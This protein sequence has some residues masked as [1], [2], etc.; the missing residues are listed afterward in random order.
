MDKVALWLGY[1]VLLA[2]G[3][4]L[5]AVCL[6]LAA[7]GVWRAWRA[8][9]GFFNIVAAFD[10]LREKQQAAHGV[11]ASDGKTQAGDA[12]S[13]A[14]T[15][16][17]R[18]LP[19]ERPVCHY[20]GKR[21]AYE[22]AACTCLLPGFQGTPPTWASEGLRA[23]LDKLPELTKEDKDALLAMACAGLDHAGQLRA[24]KAARGYAVKDRVAISADLARRLLERLEFPGPSWLENR[25]ELA[26]ELRAILAS[27]PKAAVP[28]VERDA[29][30]YRWLREAHWS[31]S[32]LCVVADPKNSVKLGVDC[33]SLGRL[34]EALDAAMHPTT[35]KERAME[36]V[37]DEFT[38]SKYGGTADVV[39]AMSKEIQRLR[40]LLAQ[41]QVGE[42]AAPAATPAEIKVLARRIAWR[43]KASSDPHHSDTY[44][45][46]EARLLQFANAIVRARTAPQM[47]TEAEAI[48]IVDGILKEDYREPEP[49][50]LEIIA[51]IQRAFA[52]KNGLTLPE[53]GQRE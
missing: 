23:E 1:A 37:D 10:A 36:D 48:T 40:T 2:G 39:I 17:L 8:W 32:P 16:S 38:A 13:E 20:T 25:A 28:E 51:A 41:L 45:F 29:A 12:P 53:G 19:G 6:W 3:V 22:G 49:E 24:R 7:E 33:P 30:R 42:T 15:T 11:S 34:D 9:R 43:F 35:A 47:L 5:C 21:C 4:G 46:N 26:A 44:T 31:G 27:A 52:S 18:G 50:D 14:E